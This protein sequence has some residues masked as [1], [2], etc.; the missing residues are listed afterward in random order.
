MRRAA[1]CLCLLAGCA[2]ADAEP[3]A[4]TAFVA[5]SNTGS[6]HGADEL[7][8]FRDDTVREMAFDGATFET[9]ETIRQ[10]RPGLFLEVAAL[11][12]AEGPGVA[13]RMRPSEPGECM[14]Y[15]TSAVIADPP[16]GGFGRVE[17]GCPDPVLDAF[18]SRVGALIRDGVEQGAPEG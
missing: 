8:L 3:P 10:G 5:V 6:I 4:G 11:V 16:L 17:S 1:L 9:E 2:G 18:M 12:A 7:Q 14:D 15:G 13:T